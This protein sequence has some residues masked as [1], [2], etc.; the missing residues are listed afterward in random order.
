M[1]VDVCVDASAYAVVRQTSGM[2]Q[3]LVAPK[4][5]LAKQE[6]TIPRLELVAGHMA[7][8]LIHNVRRVLDSMPVNSMHCRLDS[9][10]ALYW[11]CR[12][13]EYRQFV[14][15]RVRKIRA[16]EV[17]ERRH[18]PSNKNSTD[19][20]SCGGSVTAFLWWEGP[21]RLRRSDLWPPNLNTTPTPE[22]KAE[23][24]VFKKVLTRT[25]VEEPNDEFNELLVKHDL[26][27]TLR[28]C[29]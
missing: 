18:V 16:L 9:I 11:I 27:R 17:N 19:L 22:S 24:E 13:G 28:V 2:T 5:H 7:V 26:Q 4:A 29:A 23:A 10:V 14:A 3:G 12:G 6:P 15:N 1:R 20:E 21:E 8:N 25:T